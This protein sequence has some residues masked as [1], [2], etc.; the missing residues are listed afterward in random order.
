MAK[1]RQ[2]KEIW[3]LK[4]HVAELYEALDQLETA[5]KAVKAKINRILEG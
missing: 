5:I 2:D 1:E 4:R 3:E